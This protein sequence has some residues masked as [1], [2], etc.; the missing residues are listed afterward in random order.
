MTNARYENTGPPDAVQ[1][2]DALRANWGLKGG[3]ARCPGHGGQ[4]RNL[5]V[6]RA[7]DKV[8]LCCHSRRCSYQQIMA[9]LGMDRPPAPPPE[10]LRKEPRERLSVERAEY[11]YLDADGRAVVT[12]IRIDYWERGN[13]ERQKDIRSYPVGAKRPPAGW[14]LYRLPS[15]LIDRAPIMVTEGERTCEAAQE[16][17]GHRFQ[18]T[19]TLGGAHRAG[20]SDF[21]PVRGRVVTIWPD[22]DP[23]GLGYAQTVKRL[24]R[25][26]GAARVSI[27][28]TDD[29]PASWDLADGY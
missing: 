9:G 10:S 5:S 7:G 3:R 2:L 18:C 15:L 28:P 19:T 29:L 4:D 17:L 27:V 25:E 21:R 1:V 22:A 14:P 24:C 12:A 23:A 8:L 20:Q 13:P 11:P 16:L 26:H 6:R